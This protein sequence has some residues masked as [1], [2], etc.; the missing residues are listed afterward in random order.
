MKFLL[1]VAPGPRTN[2]LDFSGDP[3]IPSPSLLPIFHPRNAFSYYSPDGVI[4]MQKNQSS[5]EKYALHRV[6]SGCLVN[7]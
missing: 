6:L 5:A 3:T 1:A 7:R 2:R 4:I